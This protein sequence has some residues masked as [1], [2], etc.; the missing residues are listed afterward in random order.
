MRHTACRNDSNPAPHNDHVGSEE[1]VRS[2]LVE[3]VF[4][5]RNAWTRPRG[6]LVRHCARPMILLAG[7]SMIIMGYQAGLTD[8]RS[9]LATLTLAVAF[10]SVIVLIADLDRPVMPSSFPFGPK[11][12]LELLVS[13]V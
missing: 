13:L 7:L 11:A 9:P 4:D 10:S 5:F 6:W 2:S 1:V 12:K 8:R 3:S